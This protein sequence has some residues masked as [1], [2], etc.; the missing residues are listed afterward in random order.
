MKNSSREQDEKFLSSRQENIRLAIA[1]ERFFELCPEDGLLYERYREYLKKR[2][3]PAMEKLM[4]A[5]ETE[6]VKVFFGLDT[7]TPVQMDELLALAQKYGSTESVLWLL[8]KKEEQFGFGGKDMELCDR[9]RKLHRKSGHWPSRK[10]PA[11]VLFLC[12]HAVI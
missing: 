3:R 8:S 1:L 4:K 7:V 9:Q 6:K 2:F 5:R 11:P 12:W 10:F